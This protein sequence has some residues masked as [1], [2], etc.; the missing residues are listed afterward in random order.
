MLRFINGELVFI[1]PLLSAQADEGNDDQGGGGTDAGADDAGDQGAADDKGDE[2]GGDVGKTDNT[3]KDAGSQAK[4]DWRV[5]K[6][7]EDY[8][9]SVAYWK[10]TSS[11]WRGETDKEKKKRQGKAPLEDFKAADTTVKP[12]GTNGKETMKAGTEGEPEF[13]TVQDLLEH[14]KKN[15]EQFFES[16]FT[17]RL[18][19]RERENNFR[20]AMQRARKEQTGDPEN[21]I[22]SFA[23]LEQDVLIPLVESNPKVLTLLKELGGDPAENAYTLAI[24]VK[25]RNMDGL[26]AMFERR[27]REQFAKKLDD[28]SKEAVRVKGGRTGPTTTKIGPDDIWKMSSEEFE[29]H[30]AKETGR[31]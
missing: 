30:V 31:A 13:K 6:Y 5:E 22:P 1:E 20:S 19:E 10:D 23:E 8:E 26:K 9:N 27:G 16:K 28:V 2:G 18:T 7:G 25:S 29:K 14:V 15:Q 24:V 21:G 12:A 4:P 11:Y 3:G 17:E